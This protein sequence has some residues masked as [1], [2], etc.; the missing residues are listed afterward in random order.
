MRHSKGKAN[1]FSTIKWKLLYVHCNISVVVSHLCHRTSIFWKKM[2]ECFFHRLLEYNNYE[3]DPEWDIFFKTFWGL[4][5][6]S[7]ERIIGFTSFVIDVNQLWLTK[8]KGTEPADIIHVYYKCC[9]IAHFHKIGTTKSDGGKLKTH[10]ITHKELFLIINCARLPF[11]ELE[12]RTCKLGSRRGE[13]RD[14]LRQ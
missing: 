12:W 11:R 9:F 13:G 2:V 3:L 6:V 1:Y 7:R 5:A 14:D 4:R 10:E 8:K